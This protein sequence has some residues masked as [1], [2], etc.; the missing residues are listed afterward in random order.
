MNFDSAIHPK[1]HLLKHFLGKLE[2]AS[3]RLALNKAALYVVN[4]HGTQKKFLS[5]FKKQ[6]QFFK[7]HFTILSPDQLASFYAGQLTK[8]PYLLLTFD[9]GIRNNLLAAR[10][11]DEQNIKGLFFIVPEFINTSAG[12]QK[13]YFIRCIRP[14]INPVIDHER[15]DFEAMSWNDLRTLLNNGHGIGSHTRSHTLVAAAASQEQSKDEILGSKEL[16]FSNLATEV[17]SFCSINNTLESVGKKELSLIREL[18]TYHFTTIPGINLPSSDPYYIKRC[19]I[20]SHWLP[21]AVNYA[22]GNWDL[23]RWKKADEAYLKVL[24]SALQ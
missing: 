7:S 13:E 6:L 20:E 23:K 10:L 18:Y 3:T 17:H 24:R 22:I 2:Y 16:I 5:N 12:K 11:L 21:G 14:V 8:G 4:Y 1:N 9:D 15:E 19:N